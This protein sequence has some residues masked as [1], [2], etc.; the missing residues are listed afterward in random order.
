MYH[1]VKAIKALS[2]DTRLRIINLLLVKECCGCE[3][4]QALGISQ[5]RASRNLTMLLDAGFLKMR[6]EG[7]WSLY[8][9]DNE[10]MPEYLSKLVEAVKLALESNKVA[11]Q[12]KERLKTVTRTELSCVQ[13]V[14]GVCPTSEKV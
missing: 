13:K 5:T 10:E 2:D 6:K 8:S 3:V 14:S 1:I 7:L 9:L 12:D 4:V 11:A